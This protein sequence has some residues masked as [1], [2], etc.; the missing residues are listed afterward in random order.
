M[1]PFLA[2]SLILLALHVTV[3]PLH[4]VAS[5]TQQVGVSVDAHVPVAQYVAACAVIC[6]WPAGH[7]IVEHFACVEQQRAGV[8]PTTPYLAGS[9]NMPAPQAVEA[10]RHFC[11]SSMQHVDSSAATHE[12]PAHV[13]LPALHLCFL[14][15]PLHVY[16]EHFALFTQQLLT[17]L[18][19]DVI[20][21]LAESK[22]L[23]LPQATAEFLH[24]VESVSQHVARSADV[25]VPAAQSSPSAVAFCLSP[26]AQVIVEHFAFDEQHAVTGLAGTVEDLAASL[27]LLL[28]HVTAVLVHWVLSVWQ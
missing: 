4:F 11:S 19:P 23:V 16:D 25:H 5:S 6:F 20:P 1:T 27:N 17:P 15:A 13:K 22:Y 10:P 21:Y 24:L 8:V 14:P 2:V 9:L 18:G 26:A 28:P 3:A 7:V 12:D